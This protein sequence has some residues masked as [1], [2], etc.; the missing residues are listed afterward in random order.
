MT[1]KKTLRI[2]LM[3]FLLD[4][5]V[6]AQITL[7]TA[8]ITRN[9]TFGESFGYYF[10]TVQISSTETKYFVADT[11]ANTFDLLNMDFTP[12]MTNIA[13]PQPFFPSFFQV[14][15][16]TRSLFDCDDSTIEFAYTQTTA[17]ALPYY[18]M[19][20]DGT[21]LFAQDSSMGPYCFGGCLGGE[22]WVKPIVN[23]S[24]GAKL[25]LMHLRYDSTG[26]HSTTEIYSL[27][28]QL[29]TEVINFASQ[30]ESLVK[31]YP[32]PSSSFITYDVN[33]PNNSKE[34]D[35]VILDS[36]SKV[37]ARKKIGVGSYKGT[38]D[39]Q[40]YSSGNYFYS[41]C[42][43]DKSFQSGKFVLTK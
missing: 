29:P 16:I 21:Q 38:I 12:F 27:C 6:E 19:R 10:K 13:V 36:Q 42:D 32:N 3:L 23:T 25:F 8:V 4:S 24:S 37:I 9:N 15:Y 5:S 30:T 1:M 33:P 41:L 31:I 35:F 26:Y 43:K 18:I 17:S 20:T 11:V 14:L 22:D 28:G 34:Y 2:L 40:N 7:D 39:L